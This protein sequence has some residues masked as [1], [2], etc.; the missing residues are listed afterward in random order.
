VDPVRGGSVRFFR[1]GPSPPK[2]DRAGDGAV[3]DTVRGT[4][5]SG[6]GTTR[7]PL[8][9]AG[10]NGGTAV[11]ADGRSA[12]AERRF[13]P[14]PPGVSAVGPSPEAPIGTG[15]IAGAR[16][17]AARWFLPPP[18][19]ARHG[20]HV[21]LLGFTMEGA[22]ELYQFLERGNLVQGPLEYYATLASTLVGFYLM[23]LGVR[24]W[25]SYYPKAVRPT[26]GPPARRWPWFGVGLW[27]GG[28]GATA[29]LSTL[30]AGATDSAPPW[31]AWPVGGILVL[32]FG[33]FFFGLRQEAKVSGS[34]WG[35][36]LGWA[37]CVW[38]LGVAAVAGLV[39]GDRAVVLLTEFVTNWVALVAS[40][41]P[42]VVAMSPLFVTY[43]LM[44]GAFWPA[45]RRE[46]H[47]VG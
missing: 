44:A 10:G 25:H 45:V 12:R 2:P 34:E 4:P 24:E 47:A 8:F 39:V 31:I 13:G 35:G 46:S 26:E 9:H 20:L 22:T 15:V 29:L 42:I 33:S 19:S 36:A 3:G 21:L 27:V 37:A 18:V 28:T 6:N 41:G 5:G 32:A 17:R 38:S 7:P 43:A 14:P 23:F 40:V 16:A 1:L 11:M 30:L